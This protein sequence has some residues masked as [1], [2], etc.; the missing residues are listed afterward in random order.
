MVIR[1]VVISC[2]VCRLADSVEDCWADAQLCHGI[3]RLEGRRA[4][5]QFRHGI[6]RPEGSFADAWLLGL[7]ASRLSTLAFGSKESVNRIPGRV[8]VHDVAA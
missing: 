5:A 6:D 1:R 4:G 8:I 2:I 7:A 3:D